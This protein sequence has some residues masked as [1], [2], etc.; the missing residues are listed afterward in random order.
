M[1]SVYFCL[2]MLILHGNVMYPIV[3]RWS[4]IFMSAI[5]P[6]SWSRKVYFRYLLLNGRHLHSNLFGS[7]QTWLLLIQQVSEATR[8]KRGCIRRRGSEERGDEY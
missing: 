7:Q 5:T 8:A 6:K 2:N 1:P 4:I 3:L